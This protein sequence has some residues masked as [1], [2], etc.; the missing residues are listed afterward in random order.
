MLQEAWLL[1]KL[2]YYST[3]LLFL[4]ILLFL[5]TGIICGSIVHNNYQRQDKV[6]NPKIKRCW[7]FTI[8]LS[9]ASL[10]ITFYIAID[11]NSKNDN[12]M[13]SYKQAITSIKSNQYCQITATAKVEVNDQ[14]LILG[15]K[16]IVNHHVPS[17]T[18]ISHGQKVRFPLKYQDSAKEN[19]KKLANVFV[20]NKDT[21]DPNKRDEAYWVTSKPANSKMNYL[22]DNYLD[23]STNCGKTNNLIIVKYNYQLDKGDDDE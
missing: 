20:I 18:V 2:G 6:A 1:D 9:I 4:S 16:A 5:I 11:S 15:N 10:F 19:S 12:L 7:H 23:S 3:W 21:T 8:G 14:N 17:L 13:H 22:V